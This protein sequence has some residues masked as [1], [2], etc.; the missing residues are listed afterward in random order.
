MTYIAVK[1]N[2]YS[3]RNNCAGQEAGKQ[4]ISSHQVSFHHAALTDNPRVFAQISKKKYITLPKPPPLIR[5]HQF[6]VIFSRRDPLTLLPFATI[7]D[8]LYNLVAAAG[9]ATGSVALLTQNPKKNPH[10]LPR[11]SSTR[12]SL[13]N[14]IDSASERTAQ[15]RPSTP[16]PPPA[17][18]GPLGQEQERESR[19]SSAGPTEEVGQKGTQDID[20]SAEQFAFSARRN[21]LILGSK[22]SFQ[23]W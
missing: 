18:H 3:I 14:K 6:G 20:R 12:E 8:Q 23:V 19:A 17:F 15:P 21:C 16:E 5:S 9:A 10:P 4:I 13:R 7:R 1:P 2:W 11:P 22:M